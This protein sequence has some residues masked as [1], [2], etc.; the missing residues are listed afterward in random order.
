MKKKTLLGL[1]AV[2][3]AGAFAAA[4][5]FGQPD[6]ASAAPADA[7]SEKDGSAVPVDPD[8]T[9][10]F[11]LKN[12]FV[13]YSR[14]EDNPIYLF[15]LETPFGTK[16]LAVTWAHYETYYIGDE[17]ICAETEKGLQAI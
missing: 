6:T 13:D 9:V 17:V 15:E 7:S 16:E 4:K 8:K 11:P 14:G 5:L 12:K 3:A 2:L 10:A 1:A